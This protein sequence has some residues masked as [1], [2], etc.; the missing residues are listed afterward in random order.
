M[1]R[2]KK[3]VQQYVFNFPGIQYL[4]KLAKCT[5]NNYITVTSQ[6][7]F[8]PVQLRFSYVTVTKRLRY[9]NTSH[10]TVTIQLHHGYTTVAI[11]L[12]YSYITATPQLQYSYTTSTLQL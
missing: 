11:Q 1:H 9:G 10:N 5:I 8:K 4:H 7:R 12:Q 3:K 6:L 2:P